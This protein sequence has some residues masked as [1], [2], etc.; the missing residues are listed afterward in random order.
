MSADRKAAAWMGVLYIIGTVALVLSW[1]VTDAVLTGPA[2]LAQ[3]AAQPN[4]VAIGA[5]LVLLAGFALALVPV[6]FWPVGK[7]YNETLAIGYVVFRGGL[8]TAVYMRRRA[9]VAAADP[10]QHAAGCGAARR[11]RAHGRRP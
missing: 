3:V 9:R 7:R 6:V 1:V 2:Y 8:E 10:A 4:Q 11:L 5:L